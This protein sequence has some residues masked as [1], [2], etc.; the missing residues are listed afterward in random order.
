MLPKCLHGIARRVYPHTRD[1]ILF[2][3][4]WKHEGRQPFLMGKLHKYSEEQFKKYLLQQGYEHDYLAWIDEG[5][6]LSMRKREGKKHQY[7]IRLHSD[8]E[9][10]AHYE[11]APEAMPIHHLVCT[12]KL[13]P[14]YFKQLLKEFL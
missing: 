4:L 11:H 7:H 12:V 1:L 10:R 8:K 5:E 9:I 6:V 2:L 3:G 14:K 13:R